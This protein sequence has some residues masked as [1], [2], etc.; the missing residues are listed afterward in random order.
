MAA[1]LSVEETSNNW[2]VVQLWIMVQILFWLSLPVVHEPFLTL[3][4]PR[5]LWHP[6]QAQYMTVTVFSCELRHFMSLTIVLRI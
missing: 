6:I 2:Q 3:N 1:G 4:R 5:S